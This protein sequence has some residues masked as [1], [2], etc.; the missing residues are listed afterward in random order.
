MWAQLVAELTAAGAQ[1]Q[2]VACDVADREA[3]V[4]SLWSTAACLSLTGVIH[5]AGVLDDAVISSLT[6][7]RIDT[8]LRAKVDAAWNLHEL[9]RI[10]VCRRLWCFP[11]SR[12]GVARTGQLRG[13]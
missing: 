6:P 10:W 9:T 7:E 5:A 3:L 1:V 2:V 13:G 12:H 8:V 11:R 4:R